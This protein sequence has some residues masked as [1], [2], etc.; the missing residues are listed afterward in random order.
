MAVYPEDNRLTDGI[1]SITS[2]KR[3]QL[4]DRLATWSRLERLS[5]HSQIFVVERF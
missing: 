2:T 5:Q 1:D 3:Q 4:T